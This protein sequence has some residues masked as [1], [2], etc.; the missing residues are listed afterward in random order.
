MHKRRIIYI[1][2]GLLI[3]AVGLFS[4]TYL[5]SLPKYSIESINGISKIYAVDPLN[6]NEVLVGGIYFNSSYAHGIIGIYYLNNNTFI[7]INLGNYFNSSAIYSLSFN[8]SAILAGGA[9]YIGNQLHTTLVMIKNG[10][11]YNLSPDLSSFNALGQVFST[12]WNGRYWLVGGNGFVPLGNG[13]GELV[14]FLIKIFPNGSYHEIAQYLP[15][16]FKVLPQS[17]VYSISGNST[18]TVIAG[19]NPVNMT[20]AISQGNSNFSDVRFTYSPLGV[21]LTS[22]VGNNYVLV[23]GVNLTEPNISSTFLGV[24][25]G[26]VVQEVPLKYKVG[27]ITSI[28]YN[29]GKYYIAIAEVPFLNSTGQRIPGS[30]ILEGQTPFSL[31]TVFSEPY[32]SVESLTSIGGKVIAAGYKYSGSG[33]EG[34]LILMD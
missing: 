21:L 2:I 29:S 24:V 27:A 12:F 34:I 4:F 17:T 7:K 15:P 19:S 33:F 26:S 18:L 5:D 16:D 32:Y 11:I 20:V 1:L 9:S 14:P 23:G 22:Y 30:V 6:N 25:K 13:R 3:I 8:G 28:T 10:K 31:K